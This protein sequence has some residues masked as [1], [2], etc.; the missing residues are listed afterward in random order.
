MIT[1]SRD[2]EQLD[3]PPTPQELAEI[4]SAADVFLNLSY[5]EAQGMTTFEAL[6]CGTPVVVYNKTS[7]PEC[8]DDSC[9]EVIDDYDIDA[10]RDAIE[11]AVNKRQED[12]VKR[13]SHYRKNDCFA[14]NIA[15]YDKPFENED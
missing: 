5:E 4:Y 3:H 13:A 12:C 2:T 9:G 6:A 15:M 14:R 7:I 8:V 1:E 10:I 11:K